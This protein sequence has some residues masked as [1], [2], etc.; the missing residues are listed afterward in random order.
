VF[1]EASILSSA[2]TRVDGTLQS[3]RRLDLTGRRVER[4][5]Y[6]PS[7]VKLGDSALSREAEV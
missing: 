7:V 3:M 5:T 6:R 4:K 1:E 2:N